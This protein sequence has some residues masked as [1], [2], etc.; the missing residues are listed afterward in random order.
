[1]RRAIKTDRAPA[2]IGPY[3]QAVRVDCGSLVFCS[4][5]IPL[6]PETGE[7]VGETAAEQCKQVMENLIN[8]LAEAGVDFTTVAKTTIYLA[9]MNDFQAVNE[10][11][12][13]YFDQDPPARATVQVSRLPK[14][15]KV[16]IDAI[17]V[18]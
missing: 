8:V 13:T 16:E 9:D 4:G 7:T 3:S 5:Q 10:V 6:D 15:V 18:V 12:A 2:A 17:A 11:Y 1:M 14:D